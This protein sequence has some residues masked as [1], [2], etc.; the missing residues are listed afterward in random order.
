MRKRHKVNLIF[1]GSSKEIPMGEFESAAAAKRYVKSSEWKR[2][3]SIKKMAKGGK[4]DFMSD[5]FESKVNDIF[6]KPKSTQKIK[7]LPSTNRTKNAF[8]SL[9]FEQLSEIFNVELFGLN[10]RETEKMLEE[11]RDEWN[12]MSENER[13]GFLNANKIKFAHG[14]MMEGQ[15]VS[16]AAEQAVGSATWHRLDEMQKA[17]V[18]GE[19]V[20]DGVIGVM[21]AEGSMVAT[22]FIVTYILMDG[23]KIERKYKS[24]EDMDEGIANA[25]LEFD[26]ENIE[27]AEEK[28]A[29]EKVGLF[30]MA[31]KAEPKKSKGAP[32]PEVVVDGI[33]SEIARY[34]ELKEIINSAK[35][36]QEVI[37]GRLK[38]IGKENFLELYEEKGK[39]PENFNLKDGDEEILFIVMD[40]YKKVEPEKEAL[41]EKYDDLL[42]KVTT[43]S[44]NPE[45]LDRV[46]DVV[47][48]LIMGSKK[49]SEADKAKL[50]VVDTTVAIKKGSI[51]RLMDYDNPNEI[52][53]LIEPILALK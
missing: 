27:V 12:L 16:E 41:L 49:I 18:V 21:M 39:K 46:G 20:T 51:D 23:K 7:I 8:G 26:I 45:V 10:E 4:V 2:P 50:L 6:A 28:P 36:E 13:I 47:E 22:G 17:G 9:S 31:K 32:K 15:T 37:G 38:E 44:F 43:Y 5:E 53:D 48:E 40:K 1:H 29:K 52:F 3:Y 42:E 24:K 33:E 25:Y 19:L 30:A 11:L 35:A 14:G 34:D